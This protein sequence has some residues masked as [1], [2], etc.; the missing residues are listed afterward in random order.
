MEADFDCAIE[1]GFL[2]GV[3]DNA[4]ATAKQTI[5]DYFG[6]RFAEVGALPGTPAPVLLAG[7]RAEVQPG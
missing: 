1:V 2:P 3:T 4:G 7:G 6:F 5:E